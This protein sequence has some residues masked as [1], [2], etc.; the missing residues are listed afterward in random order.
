M[1]ECACQAVLLSTWQVNLSLLLAQVQE[2]R[3]R[4]FSYRGEKVIAVGRER[5][6]AQQQCTTLSPCAGQD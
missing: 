1:R 6:P 3:H 5:T 2:V 4:H